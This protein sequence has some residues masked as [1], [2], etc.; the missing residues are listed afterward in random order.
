MDTDLGALGDATPANLKGD[1]LS[2]HDEYRGFHVLNPS[3]GKP[4][5]ISTDPTRQDL[6][7]WDADHIGKT[8]SDSVGTGVFN[9]IL[10]RTTSAFMDIHP[11]DRQLSNGNRGARQSKE[12]NPINKNTLYPQ[13]K[14]YAII[15][16]NTGLDKGTLGKAG[17]STEILSFTNAGTPI[18]IDKNQITGAASNSDMLPGTLLEQSIAHETGHKLSRVHPLR[19]ANVSQP[20]DSANAPSLRIGELC[21]SRTIF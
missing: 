20:Y 18:L 1:G 13:R 6:F 15:Y 12:A 9:A 17:G 2:V 21:N 4:Q 10:G 3:T 14:A 8:A 7:Y 19:C 5:W 11:V 16:V